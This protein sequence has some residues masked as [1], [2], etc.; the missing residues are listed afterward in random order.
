[1]HSCT[2]YA[3]RIGFPPGKAKKLVLDAYLRFSDDANAVA[4][5]KEALEARGERILPEHMKDS[6]APV[7]QGEPEGEGEGAR[8][9]M[10][11][12]TS[13]SP[14]RDDIERGVTSAQR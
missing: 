13:R 14:A 9:E 1:M 8:E 12:D 2:H 5:P 7:A 6:R 4:P 10:R 11:P 3:C